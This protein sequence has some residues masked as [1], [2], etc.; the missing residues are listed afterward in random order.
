MNKR[1]MEAISEMVSGAPGQSAAIGWESQLL[2]PALKPPA[3]TQLQDI[4][5]RRQTEAGQVGPH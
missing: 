1:T 5:R 2:V 3:G 4:Q